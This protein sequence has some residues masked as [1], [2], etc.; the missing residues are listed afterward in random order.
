SM[1]AFQ[2]L[3]FWFRHHLYTLILKAFPAFLDGYYYFFSLNWGWT[4]RVGYNCGRN[5]KKMATHSPKPW[6]RLDCY[7]HFAFICMQ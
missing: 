3:G 6:F 4:F 1:K 5:T 7:T 2:N